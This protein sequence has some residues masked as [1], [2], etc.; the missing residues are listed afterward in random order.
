M[1]KAMSWIW[2]EHK[3]GSR[4]GPRTLAMA[5]CAFRRSDL[6][7]GRSRDLRA[8]GMVVVLVVWFK[9]LGPWR[10]IRGWGLPQRKGQ[11][12]WGLIGQSEI[13]G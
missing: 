3:A 10:S 11:E 1:G 12:I 7:Q 6:E 9:R 2:Q 8:A 13:P 5:S 4:L